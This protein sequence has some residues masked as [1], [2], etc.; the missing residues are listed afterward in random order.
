MNNRVDLNIT[1]KVQGVFFRQKT[2]EI[3]DLLNLTG[4]VRNNTDN[5]VTIIAEGSQDALKNLIELIKK[6]TPQS[7]IKKIR[8]SWQT[9]TNEFKQFE[10]KY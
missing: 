5:T 4:Y 8:T 2:K 3:A 7:N 9:T 6:G 10:I 1:G